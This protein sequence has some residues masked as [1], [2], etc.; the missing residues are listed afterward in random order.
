MYSL[1]RWDNC[2][3]LILNIIGRRRKIT[4][5]NTYKKNKRFYHKKLLNALI[6]DNYTILKYIFKEGYITTHSD[7]VFWDFFEG[8]PDI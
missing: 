3:L 7:V 1:R 5:L 8:C 6:C 4:I 2:W